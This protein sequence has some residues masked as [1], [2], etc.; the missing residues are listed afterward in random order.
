MR[1]KEAAESALEAERQRTEEVETELQEKSLEALDLQKRWKQAA[2]ELNTIRSQDQGF[3]TVT[4]DHLIKLAGGLRFSIQNFSIQYFEGTTSECESSGEVSET[5]YFANIIESMKT[6][7]VDV[8]SEE[9]HSTIQAFLWRVLVD[10]VFDNFRWLGEISHQMRAV[11]EM[12]RPKWQRDASYS[13]HRDCDAERK[14]QVWRASTSVLLIDSVL[15]STENGE[16][17]DELLTELH[18]FLQPLST[19]HDTHGFDQELQHIYDD[20][21]NLD[22]EICRQVARIEWQFPCN[23]QVLDFDPQCMVLQKGQ[24]QLPTAEEVRLVIAPRMVKRGKSTGQGF[25]TE[26]QLLPMEVSLQPSPDQ[27]YLRD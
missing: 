4:D 26:N 10:K 16:V 7:W 19:A 24:E 13:E 9:R 22:K 20:A 3:Y 6:F 11:H 15:S 18:R 23:E 14:F 1:N 21:I 2:R 25:E 12:L 17:T 8:F 5:E 27:G